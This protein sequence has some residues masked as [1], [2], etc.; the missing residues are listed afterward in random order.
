MI[1]QSNWGGKMLLGGLLMAIPFVH[2][3]ALGYLYR[4]L[5]DSRRGAPLALPD[6][7]DWRKLFMDGLVFFLFLLF[8]AVVPVLLMWLVSR[9]PL[10]NLFGPLSYVPMI[11]AVLLGAPLTAAGLYCYQARQSFKDACDFRRIVDLVRTD[12]EAMFVPTL[13][14]LG[15]L[16]AGAPVL[17]LTFFVGAVPLFW[18]YFV[19]F[20]Q[21]E[22]RRPPRL[23]GLY[24]SL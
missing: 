13:A 6:W 24:T 23:S 4:L 2:F 11:P 3:F 5:E 9:L 8:F 1:S 12:A 16:L 20:H 15:F 21:R 22:T 14:L 18:F 19:L 7:D 10:L 17:P